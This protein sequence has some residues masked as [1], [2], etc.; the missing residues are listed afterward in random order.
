LEEHFF[1]DGRILPIRPTSCSQAAKQHTH[2][3]R[4]PV[5]VVVLVAAVYAVAVL[6]ATL[7]CAAGLLHSPPHQHRL[8]PET[9]AHR[10]QRVVVDRLPKQP[11]E[12]GGSE[13]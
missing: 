12:H 5:V 3:L 8:R 6:T 13:V 4:L 9:R 1:K 7:T 2:E 10:C 11:I